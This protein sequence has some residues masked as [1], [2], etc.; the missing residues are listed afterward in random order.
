[1]A[2]QG[3]WTLHTARDLHDFPETGLH[4]GRRTTSLGMVASK[5]GS[6]EGRSVAERSRTRRQ[7][8]GLNRPGSRGPSGLLDRFRNLSSGEG[9][10][11]EG[12]L[13]NPAV[14]RDFWVALVALEKPNIVDSE[15]HSRVCPRVSCGLHCGVGTHDREGKP[16][17]VSAA[18]AV[19]LLSCKASFRRDDR[20][21]TAEQ[22]HANV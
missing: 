5:V 17:K 8:R 7:V 9:G 18:R 1:V 21:A 4:K 12:H 19:N 6:T 3:Q 2:P 11:A 15:P 13:L 16:A 20:A 10:G 22:M 14:M